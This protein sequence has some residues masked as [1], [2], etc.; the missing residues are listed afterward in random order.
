MRHLKAAIPGSVPNKRLCQAEAQI[1]P[2]ACYQKPAGT[3]WETPWGQTPLG[4][5]W[6]APQL[7]W[8]GLLLHWRG[9]WEKALQLLS[10]EALA[11]QTQ[12]KQHSKRQAIFQTCF[13]VLPSGSQ[14]VRDGFFSESF[15]SVP[16]KMLNPLLPTYRTHMV[17]FF[18]AVVTFQLKI[19]IRLHAHN[20]SKG[21]RD[22][23]GSQ[24]RSL[25]PFAATCQHSLFSGL[26]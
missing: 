23:L 2:P 14:V 20:G 25:Y 1:C 9:H 6:R 8:P 7:P 21:H 16:L 18:V 11:I 15:S 3:G 26:L 22:L 4:W 17:G 12:V 13:T 5:S 10:L 19:A 24:P